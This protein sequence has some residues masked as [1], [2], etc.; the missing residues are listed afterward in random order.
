ML[1][2]RLAPDR[3]VAAERH[4]DDCRAC[5][6]SLAAL[7]AQDEAL[8]RALEHDP[9]EAYFE[10]FA[11]RVAMRVAEG[12]SRGAAPAGTPFFGRLGEWLAIPRNLAAA[13]A[14]GAVVIGV[15]T[16]LIVAQQAQQGLPRN[17][18]IATR[19]ETPLAPA[20]PGP[21]AAPPPAA[22]HTASSAPAGEEPGVEPGATLG[23][24]EEAAR[25][26]REFRARARET[27]G[28]PPA[29]AARAREARAEL[30]GGE[31]PARDAAPGA[32]A[33]GEAMTQVKAAARPQ[34]AA[35]RDFAA[36]PA[37]VCGEVR[38]AQGRVLPFATVSLL[39]GGGTD[40]TNEQGRFCLQG[41]PG[42]DSV[43]VQMPGYRALRAAV[44]LGAVPQELRLTLD[45]A[46]PALATRGSRRG[47]GS[48]PA[49]GGAAA[50]AAT[51]DALPDTLRKVA[52]LAERLT[53]VAARSGDARQYEA[54]A[55][56]W[57]RLLASVR[58][59]G[60]EVTARG[61]IAE[62]RYH[63]W[64]ASP[65][66]KRAQAAREA[67]TAFLVRAPS[68]PERNRATLWLDQVAQ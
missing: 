22:D 16:A 44:T 37:R 26:A 62:M 41:R 19:V 48:R 33:S 25:Q 28:R 24:S 42:R 40:Q 50:G 53:E 11:D 34:A 66:Q 7:S 51:L 36:D 55:I 20:E 64:Q 2:G 57:E 27:D 13:G 10:S 5:R 43:M 67:L 61:R 49:A 58:G 6:E 4:L 15:G 59:S 60:L 17:D 21:G 18:R 47:E 12:G 30:S 3:T 23:L 29:D 14:V 54:A 35:R 68:G 32:A 9:G 8:G 63:A 52:E 65:D 31:S 46:T 39:G 56:Q 45:R 38:D 1:D